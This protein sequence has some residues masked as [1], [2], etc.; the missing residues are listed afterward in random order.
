VAQEAIMTNGAGAGLAKG[1]D[2]PRAGYLLKFGFGG[3]QGFIAQSRKTRDLA[4]SSRLISELTRSALDVATARGATIILPANAAV[5]CPHQALIRLRSK[6]AAEV[7]DCGE[8]MR[9]KVA[10]VWKGWAEKALTEKCIKPEI[11]AQADAQIADTFETYWVALPEDDRY[12][13]I[14]ARLT[15]LFEA[16]RFTRTFRQLPQDDGPHLKTCVQ[17]G[18]RAVVFSGLPPGRGF[19]AKDH[20]CAACGAKRLWSY[21]TFDQ[22]FPSTPALARDRFFRD[23]GWEKI[24]RLLNLEDD[25]WS[26]LAAA[27]RHWRDKEDGL[28]PTLPEGP[29]AESILRLVQHLDGL[30]GQLANHLEDVE[31]AIA[32]YEKQQPYYALLCFD[33]DRMGQ[34]F[35]GGCGLGDATDL[36]RFQKA[37]SGYLAGF[38]ARIRREANVYRARLVY[39][40]G[41]DGLALLPLDCVFPFA[42]A[43][44]AAWQDEVKTKVAGCENQSPTLSLHASVVHEH[45]PLSVAVERLHTRLDQ[46]KSLLSGDAFSV[47]GEPRAGSVAMLLASNDELPTLI[48]ILEGLSTWRMA[49]MPPD[50]PCAVAPN[51]AEI[52]VRQRAALPGRLPYQLLE[53][54]VGFFDANGYC[55]QAQAFG[56]EVRR[57]IARGGH[58]GNP[59]QDTLA[60]WLAKRAS[61]PYQPRPGS[62]LVL[63]CQQAVEGALAAL[64]FLARQLSWGQS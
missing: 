12:E 6:N 32:R 33:G 55:P 29:R 20:L 54:S 5:A 1:D 10:G 27:W 7:R 16:R 40:G 13:N 4:V 36:E 39:A 61:Q 46:T 51:S 59:A 44:L 21:T 28:N 30:A 19:E 2:S 26:D 48:G 45:H 52:K 38:A 17:C 3:V 60:G 49:D 9:Q 25:D 47:W 63:S 64:P 57:V 42:T 43:V 18:A 8:A 56:L 37:L 53:A 14:F 41:D 11:G 15:E 50:K 35:T 31:A 24:R 58:E 23:P 34:W 22:G 62:P